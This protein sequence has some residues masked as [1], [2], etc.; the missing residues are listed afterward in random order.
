[1]QK[2]HAAAR[3]VEVAMLPVWFVLGRAGDPDSE[4]VARQSRYRSPVVAVLEVCL[5]ISGT[6]Q[7]NLLVI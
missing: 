2:A 3:A 5:A 7:G 6:L 4:C 1:V